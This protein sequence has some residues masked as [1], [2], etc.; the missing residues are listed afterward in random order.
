MNS[1][2]KGTVD[3]NL[4]PLLFWDHRLTWWLFSIHILYNEMNMLSNW[5]NAC[6]NSLTAWME[7]RDNGKPREMLPST[8][9]INKSSSASMMVIQFSAIMKFLNIAG[10]VNTTKYLLNITL[11]LE[12]KPVRLGGSLF[13]GDQNSFLWWY[14]FN[15]QLWRWYRANQSTL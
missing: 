11:L 15:V 6:I 12:Q 8:K 14:H 7:E 4:F 10:V 3:L 2:F 1:E 13:I 9:I 5:Q